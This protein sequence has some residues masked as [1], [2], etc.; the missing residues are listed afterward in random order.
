MAF[1]RC[2]GTVA[3]LFVSEWFQISHNMLKITTLHTIL[4]FLKPVPFILCVRTRTLVG[5]GCEIVTCVIEIDKVAP[6]P[7]KDPL[8]LIAVHGAPALTQWIF[9]CLFRPCRMAHPGQRSPAAFASPSVTAW[10]FSVHPCSYTKQRRAS[11]HSS[12]RALLSSPV[13]CLSI[14]TAGIILPS[15]SPMSCLPSPIQGRQ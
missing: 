7:G 13:Q 15:I 5:R 3:F 1:F 12:W 6:L 4:L 8:S 9:D 11:C 10:L 2:I 14:R